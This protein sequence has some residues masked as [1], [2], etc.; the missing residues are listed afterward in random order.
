MPENVKII[1]AAHK[2]CNMPSDKMYLPLHVGAAGKFNDDGTPVDLGFTKDNTGDNI[3]L[4]NPYFC[5]LTGL[6][7]A[8]KNLKADYIGLVHYRRLFSSGHLNDKNNIVNSAITFGELEPM[9]GLYHVFVPR[10]RRYFIETLYSHYAHTHDANQLIICR[11]IIATKCHNYLRTYDK[12]LYRRWGYMF[13]MMILEKKLL[14]EYCSWLFTILFE[15]FDRVDHEKMSSFDKRFCGR[16]SEILFNVW[17][18]NEVISGKLDA[19]EIKELDY[20]EDV[21]WKDKIK[22]FLMAKFLGKQY[23]DSVKSGK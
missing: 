8:W 18:E 2:K 11:D 19:G 9:L 15:L 10:K 22:N 13:N 3:S 1:V 6:Y 12:V 17:L 7:W 14:N 23:K 5:E 4:E 20:V 16:I 21:V